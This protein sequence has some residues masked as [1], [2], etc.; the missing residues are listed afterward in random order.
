MNGN[1]KP[2]ARPSRKSAKSK[3][4]EEPDLAGIY[5]F[6]IPNPVTSLDGKGISEV[7]ACGHYCQA[8]AG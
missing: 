7:S 6:S 4:H 3:E 2:A 8:L 5:Y 1:G